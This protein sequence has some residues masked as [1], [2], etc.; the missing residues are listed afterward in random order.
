MGAN[1]EPCGVLSAT[2]GRRRHSGGRAALLG[3]AEGKNG[4]DRVGEKRLEAGR[5]VDVDVHLRGMVQM[6]GENGKGRGGKGRPS[7]CDTTGREGMTLLGLLLLLAVLAAAGYWGWYWW[8]NQ[9]PEPVADVATAVR[10]GQM[11]ADGVEVEQNWLQAAV[12]FRKAAEQGSAEG[13]YQLGRLY[14]EGKGEGQGVEQDWRKAAKWYQSAAEQGYADAQWKLG[15]CYR[16]GKGVERNLIWAKLWL[17]KAARKGQEEA[18]AALAQLEAGMTSAED[19]V[20]ADRAAAESGDAAAQ[21]QMAR[22]CFRGDGVPKDEVAGAEWFR[23]AAEQGY[24]EG[25]CRWGDCLREGRGVGKDE[26]AGVE[27]YRKAAEQ[28]HA[29]A[30]YRLGECLRQGQGVGQDATTAERW[31]LAAAEQGHPGAQRA[32]GKCLMAAGDPKRSFAWL[33]KAAEGGDAEGQ[34]LLA[35]CHQKGLGTEKK[36][37][38]AQRWLKVAAKN[39][40]AAA[41]SALKTLEW[42]TG[43]QLGRARQGDRRAQY[44]VGLKMVHSR[45]EKERAEGLVWIRRAALEGGLAEAAIWLGKYY[46]DK[47][48]RESFL[49][50]NRAAD[51]GSAEA[52]WEMVRLCQRG[53]GTPPSDSE[54]LRWARK[55]AE[56][57]DAGAMSFV[58]DCYA[59]GRGCRRDYEEAR[60]WYA[61]AGERGKAEWMER[62]ITENKKSLKN[63]GR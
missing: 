48:L 14:E 18:R 45:D 28:E 35:L 4:L 42:N 13:Q 51:T 56:K 47:D 50:W 59:N 15:L 52:Q 54:A 63:W 20:A 43:G 62:K 12:W 49:W 21:C 61:R 40:N 33:Q 57:G 1:S 39:G 30:Q 46:E 24:A 3:T 44:E 36:P 38:E 34:Y 29:G 26:A 37:A 27:W 25:Q 19:L 31:Y 6:N 22:R 5:K 11:Y 53:K 41:Q 16:D 9:R 60:R 2:A 17:D 32:L 8:E 7:V 58:G 55:V 23:K 10:M